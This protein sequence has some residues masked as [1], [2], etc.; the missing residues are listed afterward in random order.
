[1]R[2]VNRAHDVLKDPVQRRK[3][4]LQIAQEQAATRRMPSI[5]EIFNPVNGRNP[6]APAGAYPPAYPRDILQHAAERAQH[7][8]VHIVNGVLADLLHAYPQFESIVIQFTR[9]RS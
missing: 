8:G 3:Y 5:E 7:A 2:A 1:M 4:D 6:F 9:G